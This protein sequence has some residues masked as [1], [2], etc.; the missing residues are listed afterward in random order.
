MV[1]V[2]VAGMAVWAREGALANL[3]FHRV[4]QVLPWVEI[5]AGSLITLIALTLLTQ[6]L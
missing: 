6:T 1:T 4:A 3:P 5:L 2:A